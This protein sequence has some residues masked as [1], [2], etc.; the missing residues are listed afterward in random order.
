MRSV[1]VIMV[2]LVAASSPSITG[3]RQPEQSVMERAMTALGGAQ[4]LLAIDR[5]R[6][7][8]VE[9]AT[10]PPNTPRSRTFKIWLPDRFQSS[11]TGV[12]THTLHGTKLTIDR[13]V[14]PDIRR[15]AEQA[16]PNVF[17]RVTLAFLLRGPGL[18]SPR[19]AGN[20]TIEGMHGTMVE[21]PRS[22]GNVLKLLIGQNGQPL[23][24]VFPVR[25]AGSD[26]KRPDQVWRLEDYRTVQGV[27]FPFRLVLVHPQNPLIT[28][29]QSIEVNPPFT[30]KDFAQ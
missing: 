14:T 25:A 9:K 4:K 6:I 28:E 30:T 22:D 29:V 7:S 20:A 16:I 10:L 17:R 18:N 24:V 2:A 3:V 19:V 26:A 11:M 21:F 13:D 12:V 8:V 5:L 23:A 27:R 15:D 1:V